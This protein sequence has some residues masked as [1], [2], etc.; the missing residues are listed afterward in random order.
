MAQKK[1]VVGASIL[2]EQAAIDAKSNTVG[3]VV[4]F[5][6]MGNTRKVK[7]DKVTV[8]ADK[9]MIRVNMQLFESEEY[10]AILRHD[11]ETYRWLEVRWLPSMLRKGIGLMPKALVKAVIEHLKKRQTERETLVD[12]FM[13]KYD[14]AIKEAKKL[15]RS[16]YNEKHYPAPADARKRFSLRWN[17]LDFE[18]SAKLGSVDQQ[19]LIEERSKVDDVWKETAELVSQLLR[20][21]LSELLGHAVERLTAKKDGKKKVIRDSVVTNIKTFIDML[22][23]RNVTNDAELKVFRTKI[24]KL[25]ETCDPEMLR[26]DQAFREKVQKDFAAVKKAIDKSISDRPVRM[27]LTSDEL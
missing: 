16:L 9:K 24:V 3:I 10:D 13:V 8:D 6:R 25:L 27:V 12:A 14:A 21:E 15:L 26:D 20:A 4:Q 17:L 19:I 18:A 7:A 11:G 22:P 2:S 23:L 5:A 1:K